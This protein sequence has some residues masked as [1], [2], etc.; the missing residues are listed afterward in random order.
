MRVE[1][2][3]ID[4]CPNWQQ[5]E[6]AVRAA[7]E[8]LG[9]GDLDV[10]VRVLASEEEAAA[11]PFAGSPTI[12]IEGRDPFPS[13]GTTTDLACRIYPTPAGLRGAPSVDQLVAAFRDKQ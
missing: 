9:I 13:A 6:S 12:L 8:L 7:V 1:I 3:R 11:V 10:V 5:A 2:L 4:E